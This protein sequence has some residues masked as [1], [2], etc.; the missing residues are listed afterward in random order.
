S[1][2]RLVSSVSPAM[3]AATF[4]Q[5]HTHRLLRRQACCSARVN[6]TLGAALTRGMVHSRSTLTPPQDGERFAMLRYAANRLSE[7]PLA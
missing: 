4:P 5:P 2:R 3:S 1:L 6:A 7:P